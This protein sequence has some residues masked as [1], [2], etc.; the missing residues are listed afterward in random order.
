[1]KLIFL[2]S[3]LFLSQSIFSQSITE[4]L[5]NHQSA[6]PIEKIY[7]SH[8]QPYYA[9]G[10][11]LYGKIFLVNGRSHQY[12]DG[13]P[14]VY[15]DWI[16]E[17]GEFL[18][19]L[20]VKIKEGTAELTI[21][22]HRTYGEGRFYL[23]AYT[24]YQKNF[25]EAYIFQKEI[26]VIGETPLPPKKNTKD[27]NNFRVQFFPEGGRLVAG[28]TN[29][30]AFKAVDGQGKP[31][32]VTGTIINKNKES[33]AFFKSLN[34]GIG[35]FNLLPKTG[36]KYRAKIAWN[37]IEQTFD[38][39]TALKE[40]YILKAN[41]RDKENLIVQLAANT[42]SGLK[43]CTLV[44][45]LRGQPFFN[46]SFKSVD[47]QQLL[48]DKKAI[49][50]GVLH[51]TLFDNKERPVCE[52]LV[53][54]N[55]PTT[56]VSVNIEV[57]KLTYG[58][59]ELVKGSIEA[60]M[61]DKKRSGDM[62]VT[63]YN[64]DVFSN[65]TAGIN[66]KNYLLLQSDLKGKINNINQYFEID[67]ATSR[68][69]L[70][71][72]MLTHGWRRFSWQDVLEGNPM[73]IIFPTEENISF[74]GKVLKDNK[75]A[76]PVKADVFLNILDGQNFTS[77]NLTTDEDGLFYFKG[78]DLPDSTKVL[79]QGN[80]Y[81]EKKKRKLKQGEAKRAGNK[82]V[83]F[84]LLNLHELTFNDSISLKDIPYSRKVQTNFAAEVSRI[85]K[86]DTIYH[87]EWSIN[88]DA[89]T[90]KAQKIE[91]K[92]LR[93]IATEKLYKERGYFYSDFSQKV[94]LEDVTA[95]GAIYTNIY[96]LI[97]D[98]ISNAEIRTTSGDDPRY[99]SKIVILRGEN[100]FSLSSAAIFEVD[101]MIVSGSTAESI[102]PSEI[103]ILDVKKGLAATSIYGE[104]GKGGVIT[105]ITKEPK[106]HNRTIPTKG[107]L[108]V[109]HPGYHQA[110][111][112]YTP[113]YTA[114]GIDKD[115][116]DYRTT[117]YWDSAAKMDGVEATL[118]S[119]Y[120]GDKLAEFLIFVEGITKDG[121]PFV[122]QKT[123]AVAAN[124]N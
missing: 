52:R 70:D 6:Y 53:F 99:G 77:T 60:L 118:F 4:K 9:S 17:K 95:G 107:I 68:T 97:R 69:L 46:Q 41:N 89:I 88:L 28:L 30:V 78:F 21:P 61:G 37:G 93:K 100:S 111:T 119:F 40:G 90:V 36:E 11:T 27:K 81:N 82:N 72:V 43:G 23:R 29:K 49:P 8:N 19:S 14:I 32:D 79:I 50:A 110:R 66:I 76:T 67:D 101:G 71:Y 114:D 63:V 47:K 31:I 109:Q 84:E 92:R 25:D 38:L 34:E 65:G 2:L 103:A 13:A 108:T 42:K 48:L 121:Q 12:F 56:S 106:D 5:E 45:H 51:F 22:L 24:Q 58:A 85:R 62:T 102:V 7:I 55:N 16:N 59:K 83:Q 116:P 115:K 20:I 113:D 33:I 80:V 35:I 3:L 94:Y 1:M 75:Q 73:P 105:I 57:P 122:G 64:K 39:P 96:D 87:P 123:I 104:A 44:G 54:N 26:R 120:T 15:V 98:R 112:F 10:D 74:A 86:V 117:L 18:E 124:S 91:K